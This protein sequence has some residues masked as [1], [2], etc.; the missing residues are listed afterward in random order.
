MGSLSH[1]SLAALVVLGMDGLILASVSFGLLSAS[2][3][4]ALPRV[5]ARLEA[6]M[7]QAE[8][9]RSGWAG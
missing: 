9:L 3:G 1:T 7:E 2:L 6:R 4:T 8:Q 5:V